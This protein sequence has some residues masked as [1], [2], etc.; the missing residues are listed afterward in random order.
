MA[1]SN[2]LDDDPDDAHVAI[3]GVTGEIEP[4]QLNNETQIEINDPDNS[5]VIND[6]RIEV[7]IVPEPNQEATQEVETR[8]VPNLP[9]PQLKLEDTEVELQPTT[10]ITTPD[11]IPGVRRS[12]RIKFPTK[13]EYISSISGKSKYAYAVTQL[14]SHG[15]LHPDARMFFQTHLYEAEPDVV[16]VM[17]TQLS[18][19]AGLCE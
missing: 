17:I 11:E 19:V 6:T 2:D 18:L 10:T 12:T 9:E 4:P 1:N 8:Q 13:Q 16:A 15:A 14:E 5:Q 3:P 7:D